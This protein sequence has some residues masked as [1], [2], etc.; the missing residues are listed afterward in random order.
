MRDPLIDA[1][2]RQLAELMER[3][4]RLEQAGKATSSQGAAAPLKR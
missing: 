3:V 2:Q 1:M 4:E